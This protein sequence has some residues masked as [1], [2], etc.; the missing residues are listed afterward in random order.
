VVG[1]LLPSLNAR[2]HFLGFLEVT[3]L[4]NVTPI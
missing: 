1:I 3:Y 2:F 4:K